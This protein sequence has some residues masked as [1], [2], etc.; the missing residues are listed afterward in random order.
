MIRSPLR[1]TARIVLIVA[2]AAAA[3]LYWLQ[4]KPLDGLHRH[5]APHAVANDPPTAGKDPRAAIPM[6][7]SA[8]ATSLGRHHTQPDGDGGKP[9]GLGPWFARWARTALVMTVAMALST[10]AVALALLGPRLCERRRRARERQRYE[11]IPY[12]N[13]VATP[14]RMVQVFQALGA[15]LGRRWFRR[16]LAGAPTIAL[17]TH[18]LPR[19]DGPARVVLTVLCSPQD[20]LLVDSCLQIAYPDV[21]VGYEFTVAP[22]PARDAPSWT[23]Y[24]K[25]LTKLRPFIAQVGTDPMMRARYAS[26]HQ[27]IDDLLVNLAEV[28]APVSVQLA[29]TPAPRW[30]DRLARRAYREEEHAIAGLRNAG[31]LG[32]RSPSADAELRGGLASQHQLLFYCDIRCASCNHDV[33]LLAAQSLS[34]AAG[35]NRLRVREPWL[36]RE[37]HARRIPKGMP[38][39]LP[40]VRHGILS[41]AELAHLW[42]LPS[43]R[44]KSVA[45]KRSNLMREPASAAVWQV[46]LVAVDHGGHDKRVAVRANRYEPFT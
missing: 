40:P 45:I 4:G 46:H 12:R 10:L 25:R 9:A 13:D 11:L 33:A 37:L 6:H 15:T 1:E 30:V 35:V 16:L 21:R 26:E 20:A 3:A 44:P 39:L 8:V 32:E 34:Q 5:S 41:S 14:E 2:L 17:E 36:L 19:R 22:H 7:R 27:L 29:I 18:I 23:R 24:V 42:Q 28:K 43:H 38:K 31:E